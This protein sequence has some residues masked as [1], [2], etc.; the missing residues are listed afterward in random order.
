MGNGACGGTRIKPSKSARS[1]PKLQELMRDIT[2]QIFEAKV[3]MFAS[4]GVIS[5]RQLDEVLLSGL[6]H[7]R[8]K[9]NELLR[10]LLTMPFFHVKD[11]DNDKELDDESPEENKEESAAEGE[12]KPAENAENEGGDDEPAADGAD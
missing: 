6:R 7:V 8:S 5:I 2:L 4:D 3:K 10:N 11:S 1:Q 12:E 9:N